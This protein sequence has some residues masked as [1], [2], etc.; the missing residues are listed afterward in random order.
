MNLDLFLIAESA[1][2]RDALKLIETNQHGMVLTRN[3]SGVVTG[4]ATDGHIRRAL[5][6][7]AALDSPIQKCANA[8]FV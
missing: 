4:L 5:L 6:N 3:A 8:N 7:G 2:L 1:P